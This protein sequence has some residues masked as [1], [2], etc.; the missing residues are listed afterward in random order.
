MKKLISLLLLLIA[1]NICFSQDIITKR[2]KAFIQAKILDSNATEIIYKQYFNQDGPTYVILKADLLKIHYESGKFENYKDYVAPTVQ[3][4]IVIN[5]VEKTDSIN[6]NIESPNEYNNNNNKAET[7]SVP[8]ENKDIDYYYEGEHDALKHYHDYKGV[9]T[10]T[11]IVSSIPLAGIFFGLVP[12][13]LFTAIPPPNQNLNYPNE[14]LMTIAD[15]HHAYTK[16]AFQIKRN[17]VLKN[18]GLGVLTGISFM[19]VFAAK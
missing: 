19:I 3:N 1:I 4:I 17:K 9:S 14:K 11:Y 5:K 8:W 10:F 7:K 6:E 13:V 15:Y 12:T 16:K 18:Y 2:N